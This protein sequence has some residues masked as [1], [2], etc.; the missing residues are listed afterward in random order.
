MKLIEDYAERF[1]NYII[2]SPDNFFELKNWDELYLK[3]W[4]TNL[5]INGEIKHIFE[6]IKKMF[7]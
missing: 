6:C 2:P 5:K 1:N 7:K 4:I 3:I